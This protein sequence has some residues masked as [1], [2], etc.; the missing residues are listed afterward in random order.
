ML[1]H[2]SGI[3]IIEQKSACNS[4]RSFNFYNQQLRFFKDIE[5]STSDEMIN[6]KPVNPLIAFKEKSD[7]DK[8]KSIFSPV[9]HENSTFK[10][11]N[12]YSNPLGKKKK[13]NNKKVKQHK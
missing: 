9:N 13:S 1:R 8:N 5:T 6:L 10:D 4:K 12:S 2:L 3:T 11:L 7:L